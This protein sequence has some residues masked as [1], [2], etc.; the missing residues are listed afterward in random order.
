MYICQTPTL[1]RTPTGYN[2]VSWTTRDVLNTDVDEQNNVTP[3][4]TKT[5]YSR[6]V[7]YIFSFVF[8]LFSPRWNS[9]GGEDV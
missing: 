7:L 8:N 5:A 2:Y 4:H 1:H 6:W 9:S 3:Y